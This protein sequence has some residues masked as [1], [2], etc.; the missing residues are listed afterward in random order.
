MRTAASFEVVKSMVAVD[1]RQADFE[2]LG[3]QTDSVEAGEGSAENFCR[4]GWHI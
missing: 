2:D 1:R 4:F 3:D